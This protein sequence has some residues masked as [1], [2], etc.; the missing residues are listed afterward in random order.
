MFL[1]K[2]SKSSKEG[3]SVVMATLPPSICHESLSPGRNASA[4]RTSFGTV[5]RPFVV[6]VEV[7]MGDVVLTVG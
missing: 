6:S 1:M 5:V 4:S 3:R 7:G 2:P